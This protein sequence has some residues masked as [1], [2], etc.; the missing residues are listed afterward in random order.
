[1]GKNDSFF[2]FTNDSIKQRI[3]YW[4]ND[5]TND[6]SVR[7]WT[8]NCEWKKSIFLRMKKNTNKMGCSGLFQNDIRTK[9][10]K[11]E[12]THLYLGWVVCIFNIPVVLNSAAVNLNKASHT[13]HTHSFLSKMASIDKSKMAVRFQIN[14][15]LLT[16][17]WNK[18]S[19]I[20]AKNSRQQLILSNIQRGGFTIY[21]Y[22]LYKHE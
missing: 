10:N 5:I 9:E 21:Y 3:L 8:I 17:F 19:L 1:M 14:E 18:P 13:V 6:R 16:M 22:Y 11:V 12:R 20:Y 4:T 2:T 7:K 15:P